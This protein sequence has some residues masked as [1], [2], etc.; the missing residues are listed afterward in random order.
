MQYHITVYGPEYKVQR[1]EEANTLIM[2]QSLF[3]VESMFGAIAAEVVYAG[4][5]RAYIDTDTNGWIV[6][7]P[8][9]GCKR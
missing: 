7:E 9:S 1:R 2:A 8:G 6:N 3:G 4:E 5:V